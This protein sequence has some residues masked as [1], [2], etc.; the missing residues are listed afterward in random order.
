MNAEEQ[1]D[2]SH[3][4]NHRRVWVAIVAIVTVVAAMIWSVFT[5]EPPPAP[6]KPEHKGPPTL[7]LKPSVMVPG[8]MQM[9]RPVE[10]QGETRPD[11]VM[12]FRANVNGTGYVLLAVEMP[13]GQ[14]VPLY[15]LNK[16][17]KPITDSVLISEDGN[18]IG[19]PL[20]AHKSQA[21]TVVALLS[22]IPFEKAPERIP[23]EPRRY[24][25]EATLKAAG[26]NT[27]L[28]PAIPGTSVVAWD[29][30]TVNVTLP[31]PPP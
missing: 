13:N 22:L 9:P 25:D 21:M 4:T 15:G 1:D 23:P 14:L 5:I 26:D 19:Y 10:D 31:I 8:P 6:P 7:I 16:G 11:E 29:R 20:V 27:T 12:I 18:A 28:P 3:L 24:P 30:F 2:L 17:V